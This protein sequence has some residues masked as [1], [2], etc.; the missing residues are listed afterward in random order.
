MALEAS[1]QFQQQAHL[2]MAPSPMKRRMCK[3]WYVFGFSVGVVYAVDEG[4]WA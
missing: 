1:K 2:Q 3:I 4:V